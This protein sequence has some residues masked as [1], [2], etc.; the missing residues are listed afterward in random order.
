MRL[1]PVTGG[2]PPLLRHEDSSPPAT[3]PRGDELEAATEKQ[4]DRLEKLQRLL[5]ADGRFAVLIVLQGRDASGKDGVIKKVIGA[6]NPMGCEI[7]SFKAPTELE[8]KHDFLWRVHARTPAHGMIGV[9]NRSHYEDVLVVRV[10]KLAPKKIWSQ[11][12]DQINEF[13]RTLSLNH[14]IVLKFMLHISSDEQKKRLKAR[15]SDPTKNWKFRAEDLN[16]RAKWDDYTKAYSEALTRC[17][18]KW[19]PWYVVPADDKD[20]RDLLVARTIAD[21]IEQLDLSFPKAP[22][23][24]RKLR[25]V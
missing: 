7:T 1:K 15:L 5:Y 2:R 16:D 9:F 17:S 21:K 24:V 3:V 6:V 8:R 4:L 13:E 18:T 22:R 23:E 25:I 10:H 14:T 12:F 11:R 20:V 19:A